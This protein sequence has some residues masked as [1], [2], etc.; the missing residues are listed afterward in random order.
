MDEYEV[1]TVDGEIIVV[2]E[3]ELAFLLDYR[4]ADDELK[5]LIEERINEFLEENKLKKQNWAQKSRPA[6]TTTEQDG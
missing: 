6:P 1:M 5:K 4:M 3:E 2:S